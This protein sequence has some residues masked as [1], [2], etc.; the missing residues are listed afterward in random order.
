[1]DALKHRMDVAAEAVWR[2]GKLTLR[3]FQT[4]IT[5]DTKADSSPVTVADRAAE[6]LL[7]DVLRAEF[8]ADGFVG[9]EGGERP[10]TSGYRWII[11]PIDGTKSFIQGVP[12]YAVLVGLEDASKESVLGAIGFPALGELVVAARGEGC[13]VDGRRARVSDVSELSRACVVFTGD[14]EFEDSG[15]LDALREIRRRARITRGWGDAYGHVLV[16]TGRAE[17]MLDP[18]LSLWDVAPL[19][20]IVEEA[21]GVF[22]D[23]QGRRTIHGASGVSTNAALAADVRSLIPGCVPAPRSGRQGS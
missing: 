12:L 15:R 2:A 4:A 14:G 1:M 3:Y 10:G 11:D 23:W 19:L 7:V 20:P 16:A 13:Y 6:E 8:P 21:G 9:E 18:V 22:T 5:V 17:V